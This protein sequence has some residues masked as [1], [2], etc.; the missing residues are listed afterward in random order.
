[1]TSI[2]A[3]GSRPLRRPFRS[4]LPARLCLEVNEEPFQGSNS[5]PTPVP[6][7]KPFALLIR[8]FQDVRKVAEFS[9]VWAS[10]VQNRRQQGRWDVFRG[11]GADSWLRPGPASYLVLRNSPIWNLG[12]PAN[13]GNFSPRTARSRAE[14]LRMT[15]PKGE[16]TWG[17]CAN[18]ESMF[19]P[20]QALHQGETRGCGFNVRPCSHTAQ[21]SKIRIAP[22][23]LEIQS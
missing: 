17:W 11:L 10:Q 2:Y 3:A 13:S 7:L 18:E 23:L 6:G 22:S 16:I 19:I 4:G 5:R 20:R 8:S 14:W 15:I 9:S 1:M 21:S 12:G